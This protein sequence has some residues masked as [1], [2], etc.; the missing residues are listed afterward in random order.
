[1]IVFDNRGQIGRDISLFVQ[2]AAEG[3]AVVEQSGHAMAAQVGAELA[4][5]AEPCGPAVEEHVTLG[6]ARDPGNLTGIA[7]AGHDRLVHVS[8]N[9]RGDRAVGFTLERKGD[10]SRQ[11]VLPEQAPDALVVG[12]AGE[13]DVEAPC[14]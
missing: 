6:P 12:G 9:G 1:V 8:F 13:P 10:I 3:E 11:R 5:I 14:L 7:T 2:G 4:Q